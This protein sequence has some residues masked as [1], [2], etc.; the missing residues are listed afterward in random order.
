M[1]QS[2]TDYI[3]TATTSGV[4]ITDGDIY[5]IG[6]PTHITLTNEEYQKLRAGDIDWQKTIAGCRGFTYEDIGKSMLIIV[7]E[8]SASTDI[9]NIGRYIAISD[10]VPGNDIKQIKSFKQDE[11]TGWDIVPGGILAFNVSGDDSLAEKIKDTDSRQDILDYNDTLTIDV[12]DIKRDQ[13][14]SKKLRYEL[15]E[16][17]SGSLDYFYTKLDSS[18]GSP[19]QNY[20]ENNVNNNSEIISV[21]VN[22][23]F[24]KHTGTWRNEDNMPLK[25][26]RVYSRDMHYGDTLVDADDRMSAYS[27]LVQDYIS[28]LTPKLSSYFLTTSVAVPGVKEGSSVCYNP[29]NDSYIVLANNNST[30]LAVH[31]F[32]FD[33]TSQ[34]REKKLDLDAL[35]NYSDVEGICH[36]TGNTFALCSEQGTGGRKNG[37]LLFEY[38]SSDS[39][40]SIDTFTVYDT[41]DISTKNNK[42]L[43]G[44]TYNSKKD[45]YYVVTEGKSGSEDWKVYEISLGTA[46]TTTST[47]LFTKGTVSWSSEPVNISDIFFNSDLN[48]LFLLDH[49]TSGGSG[50]SKI[51]QCDLN[52]NFITSTDL[53]KSDGSAYY[54]LEGMV[55]S[56]G[57][58]EMVVVG[59]T[60]NGT[61]SDIGYYR[62]TLVDVVSSPTVT[63]QTLL[64]AFVAAMDELGTCKH[65]D[66]LYNLGKYSSDQ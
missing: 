26:V 17:H 52:G 3:N 40:S 23:Y 48:N 39:V 29:S 5:L 64:S 15:T 12:V 21:L 18:G 24:S 42:G 31:E 57:Q 7:N 20:L 32:L 54:Q 62:S 37:I 63:E 60:S 1:S 28:S 53:K 61:I 19:H 9:N 58:G 30:D 13:E 50:T 4:D 44:I 43:E 14:D 33:S 35:Y 41:D 51:W 8:G 36:V 34:L 27:T 55:F 66:N 59:E 46:P 22:P 10:N 65:G 6:E 25:S 38:T 16:Q 2:Y 11:P 45:V 49:G 47:Q 56:P